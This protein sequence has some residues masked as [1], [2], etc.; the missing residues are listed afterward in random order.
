M[1]EQTYSRQQ[2]ESWQSKLEDIAVLPRTTFT[3]RQAVEEMIDSIEKALLA[4]SYAEVAAGL[5]EWGLDISEG[6]LKQ[7]VT[8]YRKAMA[9]KGGK[10]SGRKRAGKA[11]GKRQQSSAGAASKKA[12]MKGAD[13]AAQ[14]DAVLAA[15]GTNGKG[16]ANGFLEMPEDL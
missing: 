3:K 9:D 4:R 15:I 6:A 2:V 1:A 5:S 13:K 14:K 12:A 8:R 16:R 10:S 11:A 7:Y